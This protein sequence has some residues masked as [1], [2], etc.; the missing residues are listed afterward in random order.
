MFYG[1]VPFPVGENLVEM[2]YGP[3][4]QSVQMGHHAPPRSVSSMFQSASKRPNNVLDRLLDALLRALL[5]GINIVDSQTISGP[6]LSQYYD[7]AKR[8]KQ[9]LAVEY[10]LDYLN[11]SLRDGK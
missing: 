10:I 1:I 4:Q 11:P 6:I 8:L 9:R 2:Q 3:F 5:I 7:A